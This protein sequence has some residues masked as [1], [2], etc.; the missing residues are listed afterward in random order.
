M[1]GLSPSRPGYFQPQP[2]VLVPEQILPAASCARNTVVSRPIS[3]SIA[4]R[5]SAASGVSGQARLLFCRHLVVEPRLPGAARILDQVVGG[6]G[7]DLA[8]ETSGALAHQELVRQPAHDLARDAD[9]MQDSPAARRPRRCAACVPSIMQASSSISPSR[10]G[11]PPRPTVRT[12][13]SASI[14]R[15]PASIASSAWAPSAS[16]RAVVG[17]PS[18]PSL[19][20]TRI[21]SVHREFSCC[22]PSSTIVIARSALPPSS[23]RGLA[24][25]STSCRARPSQEVNGSPPRAM[26]TE[27][28]PWVGRRPV[29]N[30]Q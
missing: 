26:T 19:L 9:R 18:V 1:I 21:M 7:A 30:W 10:F 14:R 16:M 20:V 29:W 8:R 6:F 22:A 15:M 2:D 17:T 4:W 27:A 3:G 23:W 24:P 13:G 12:D 28:K 25:P 5:H 11:Q